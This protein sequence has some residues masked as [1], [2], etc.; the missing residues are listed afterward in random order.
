MTPTITAPSSVTPLSG[1]TLLM[2]GLAAAIGGAAAMLFG[3]RLILDGRFDTHAF[4][5]MVAGLFV[6]LFHTHQRKGL[7]LVALFTTAVACGYAVA[8]N[9]LLHPG[10]GWIFCLFCIIVHVAGKAAATTPTTITRH[11]RAD[12]HEKD[13]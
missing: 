10:A 7:G 6:L 9:G 11:T 1:L 13:A 5:V 8:T 12:A 3:L 4:L 2:A